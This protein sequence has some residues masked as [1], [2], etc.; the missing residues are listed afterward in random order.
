MLQVV[1]LRRAACSLRQPGMSHGETTKFFFLR[2]L[3]DNYQHSNFFN[4][5]IFIS[6]RNA[7]QMMRD[8]NLILI[9]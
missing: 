4:K 6:E 1:S 7:M 9:L 5:I 2:E 3:I 8:F